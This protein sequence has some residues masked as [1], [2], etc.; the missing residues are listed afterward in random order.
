MPINQM[1]L[2]KK[3]ASVLNSA[4]DE[5]LRSKIIDEEQANKLYESYET[6]AFDWM[7][8]AKY[9]FW[10]SIICI[11][12]SGGAIVADDYLRE[13]LAKLF[14]APDRNGPRI[15]NSRTSGF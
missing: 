8:L 10:I 15:V 12:I 6:V 1:Q 3:K 9:S 4:I 14:N 13:L 2:T 5:W 7:R 11:I